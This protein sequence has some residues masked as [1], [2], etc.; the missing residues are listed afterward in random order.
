MVCRHRSLLQNEMLSERWAELTPDNRHGGT[1]FWHIA[2]IPGGNE[3]MVSIPALGGSPVAFTD[4]N[5]NQR[6]IPLSQLFF[7]SD[8]I[9]A[10]NWPP[11]FTYKTIV[12][13][14][15]DYLVAQGLLVPGAVPKGKPALTIKARQ[16]GA[17]GNAVSIGFANPVT[18][19]DPSAATVDTTVSARQS[20]S[21]LTADSLQ[22]VLGTTTA[23]GS[24][25]GLVVLVTP[26]PAAGTIPAAGTVA[27]A[28]TPAEFAIPKQGGGTAF[29][30]QAVFNTA[31]DAA[32]AALLTVTI[33]D[34]DPASGSFSLVVN[35]TKSVSAT[36]LKD[37][38]TA[39]PFAFLVSF[40]APAGGLI[41]PPNA[42]A[43]ALQGGADNSPS[44]AV[45]AQATALMG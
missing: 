19:A 22:S 42:G 8:G 11:Y 9:K 7:D 21:L 30:L 18:N 12:D 4:T 31:A 5:G 3:R 36:T 37:L 23:T 38:E 40:A 14:W 25:P 33:A 16:D 28:G 10:T 6:E 34:V 41:G 20:W 35:W 27:A 24:Q 43:I 15:L 29:T 44:G 26:A 39:N 45:T 1:A 13:P 32:D 17:A 2:A